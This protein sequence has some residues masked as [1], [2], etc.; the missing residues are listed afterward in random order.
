MTLGADVTPIG[1]LHP[2]W[3]VLAFQSILGPPSSCMSSSVILGSPEV[4][5]ALFGVAELTSSYR[6]AKPAGTLPHQLTERGD[7]V[8]ALAAASRLF[9]VCPAPEL[10]AVL[11]HAALLGVC[12]RAVLHTLARWQDKPGR[13]DW[14][15]QKLTPLGKPVKECTSSLI[16]H[17]LKV[18]GLHGS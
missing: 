11:G 13:A 3:A 18:R 6:S 10:A 9:Q 15:L 14:Q 12:T 4:N 5:D 2:L 1:Q 8:R 7:E 16:L 17:N